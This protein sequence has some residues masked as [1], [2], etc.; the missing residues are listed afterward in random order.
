M[1]IA[2]EILANPLI[3]LQSEDIFDALKK[4]WV[5][6]HQNVRDPEKFVEEFFGWLKTSDVQGHAMSGPLRHPMSKKEILRFYEKKLKEYKLEN[7]PPAENSDMFLEMIESKLEGV[8]TILD[9]GCGKLTFLKNIAAQNK[10]VEKFI[11]IDAKSNPVLGDLDPRIEF[12]INLDRIPDNSVDLAVVKLVLHHLKESEILE[13]LKKI[14]N[15]LKPD[16]KLILFEESFP[17]AAG[18]R[19]SLVSGKA[20]TFD[21][22]AVEKYLK[23]SN[24][25]TSEATADFMR[26][27]D[28]DKF[29]FLFLNDWLMNLQNAYMPWTLEYR[30]MESWRD[31]IESL[32][33][34]EK[35]AHFIG[36]IKNRKR[37]Q[38]M[39]AILI[40]EN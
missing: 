37:K 17:E 40:F 36:A 25:E 14:K 29:K 20:W 5:L 16:G 33:F 27:S 15:A 13:N 35:E 7:L 9:F 24:L 12:E 4:H 32:G 6:N 8:K 22:Q 23:K 1:D 3:V 2:Q 26:L 28:E 39:T 11:G 18:H 34:K 19:M 21:V 31:L 38:G 30:S 10:N